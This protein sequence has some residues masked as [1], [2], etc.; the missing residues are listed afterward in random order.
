M[1]HS[2]PMKCLDPFSGSLNN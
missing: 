2:A 1:Q